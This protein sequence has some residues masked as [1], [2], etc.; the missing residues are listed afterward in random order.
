MCSVHIHRY[1]INTRAQNA[2]INSI[3]YPQSIENA[4][5]IKKNKKIKSENN[6]RI[7]WAVDGNEMRKMK[8]DDDDAGCDV[9]SINNDSRVSVHCVVYTQ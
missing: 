6:P 3:T 5:H 9:A 7:L 4:L 8:S 2:V 1:S